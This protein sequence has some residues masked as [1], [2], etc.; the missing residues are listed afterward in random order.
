MFLMFH[1]FGLKTI[2]M[3]NSDKKIHF[4]KRLFRL[5]KETNRL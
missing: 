1:F 2:W 3:A 4:D 5:D